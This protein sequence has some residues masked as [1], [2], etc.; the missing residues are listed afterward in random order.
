MDSDSGQRI[1]SPSWLPPEWMKKNLTT[2]WL[3]RDDCLLLP[4]HR[5]QFVLDSSAI[6]E[7]T[8]A[9]ILTLLAKTHG[10]ETNHSTA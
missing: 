2:M 9:A 6:Q 4:T 3:V 8:T 1:S 7:D 10:I 5:D